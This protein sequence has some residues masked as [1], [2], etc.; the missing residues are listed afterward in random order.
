[1]RDGNR[2]L[3]FLAATFMAAI[4]VAPGLLAAATR[5]RDAEQLRMARISARNYLFEEIE[6]SHP[7]LVRGNPTTPTIALTFDDGPH[8][9][10]TEQLLSIL[11]EEKVKAT[12]FVVG[13]MVDKR[14]HL[15]REIAADGHEVASHTY[16]HQRLPTLTEGQLEH[17]LRAGSEAIERV[18]NVAPRFYR[19]PGGEYDDRVIEE[20]KRLG[21]TMVLWT[22]DPADFAYPSAQL[23]EQRILDKASNGGI[24]LLHD[25][26][27]QTMAMLPDLIRQLKARGY[28]FVTC[29]ELAREHGAITR[30]G[31]NILPGRIRLDRLRNNM[32]IEPPRPL[33]FWL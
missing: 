18:L 29:S 30:G 6:F 12:F 33:R 23:I 15:V 10:R 16:S 4:A 5:A 31:P 14:P 17:E 32:P 26:I 24:V 20:T 27:P 25:G 28:R 3:R 2:A 11:R 22:A 1:M 21:M 9:V 13:K 19:P 7:K 8:P